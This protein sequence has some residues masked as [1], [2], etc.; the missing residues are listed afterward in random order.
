[1][2]LG[3]GA[4]TA[5]AMQPRPCDVRV[6][7]NPLS[8]AA[9]TRDKSDFYIN[10]NKITVVDADNKQT[11]NAFEFETVYEKDV[12]PATVDDALAQL[13]PAFCKGV[14]GVL[15]LVGQSDSGK[16]ELMHGVPAGPKHAAFNG[17]AER[18]ITTVYGHL[19]DDDDNVRLNLQHLNLTQERIQD[20]MQPDC[21]SHDLPLR[22]EAD[23]VFVDGAVHGVLKGQ[24]MAVQLVQQ[25]AA[26][27]KNLARYHG[28]D[29]SAATAVLTLTLAQSP[30][31]EIGATPV[32]RGSG[33]WERNPSDEEIVSTLTIVEVPGTEK[34]G[35]DRAA[36]QM[37]E[38]GHLHR[39]VLQFG[40]LVA[41]LAR[42]R[43]PEH[44][45]WVPSGGKL[46]RL[47]GPRLGANAR[48]ACVASVRAGAPR[49]SLATLRLARQ[50]KGVTCYPIVNA[51]AARGLL[52]ISRSE[53]LALRAD[54]EAMAQRG[55]PPPSLAP[56]PPQAPSPYQPPPPPVAPPPLAVPD[57][58]VAELEAKLAALQAQQ[59][60]SAR[61][62]K[63]AD[64]TR[65]SGLTRVSD[66][67][68]PAPAEQPEV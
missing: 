22:D 4:V 20:L 27:L 40:E 23:G 67:A 30:T 32:T 3:A 12:P 48:I 42:R 38:Q 53:L 44:V 51:G 56:P 55:L 17:I 35:E 16:A 6:Y 60:E 49:A 63:E 62:S 58:K 25:S 64:D 39:S 28:V 26:A 43:G 50:L 7:Q 5:V 9:P 41:A 68:P 13:V 65:A 37:R 47:V 36:L 15:L 19:G 31:N 34:L 66:G 33:K 10:Q 54:I 14:N 2:N 11:S 18:V 29:A 61:K 52:T 8:Q 59:A 24:P 45:A 46:A 1:M 57:P 21:H